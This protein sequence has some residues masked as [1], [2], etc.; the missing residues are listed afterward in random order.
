MPQDSCATPVAFPVE[1]RNCCQPYVVTVAAAVD[2]D[3][4]AAVALAWRAGGTTTSNAYTAAAAA[5]AAA[6][7]TAA[8]AADCWHRHPILLQLFFDMRC[9]RARVVA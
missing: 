2:G 3:S 5:A 9:T 8:A 1:A 4:R 7:A 6:A